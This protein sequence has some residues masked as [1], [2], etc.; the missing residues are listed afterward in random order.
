MHT[1]AERH[2]D[3]TGIADY[4]SAF[5][6]G[7]TLIAAPGAAAGPAHDLRSSLIVSWKRQEQRELCR[8][9][10]LSQRG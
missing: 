6:S 4:F 10:Y 3:R 1:Q 9:H 7:N 5:C 2:P 8:G